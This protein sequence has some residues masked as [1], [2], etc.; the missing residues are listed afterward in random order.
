M[1][2]NWWRTDWDSQIRPV[3]FSAECSLDYSYVTKSPSCPQAL[4]HL[5]GF[6]VWSVFPVTLYTRTLHVN[7]YVAVHSRANMYVRDVMKQRYSHSVILTPPSLRMNYFI[8]RWLERTSCFCFR[9]SHRRC[10]GWA[11]GLTHTLT[12]TDVDVS[13]SHIK[14]SSAPKGQ[15]KGRNICK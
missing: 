13:L 11:E 8:P 14:C 4:V 5:T 12:H 9:C 15:M 1:C 7:A 2:V 6:N 3:W 10:R